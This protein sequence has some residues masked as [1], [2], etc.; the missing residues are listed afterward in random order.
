MSLE[1]TTILKNYQSAAIKKIIKLEEEFDG[2]LNFLEAGLGKSIIMLATLINNPVKTL[3]VCPAG[4]VNNWINEIKK[5]TNISDEKIL[6]YYGSNRKNIIITEEQIIYITSYS[7]VSREFNGSKFI[8]NSLFNNKVE[9]GRIILDEAHYIRN[10]YS[11]ISKSINFLGENYN[12][13]IK[14]WIVTATPIFN[15]TIDAY[16]Y[17]KFL[18]LEGI[19]SKADWTIAITKSIDGI[20]KLNMW[21]KKYGI[22][23]LKKDVLKE[24]SPKI[25]NKVILKFSSIEQEFYNSLKEYSQTRM[26]NLVD[27]IKYLNK[28]TI[29]DSGM[30]KIFHSNVMVYILRLKQACDSPLI[31]LKCMDRLK[32]CDLTTGVQKLK[33][34]NDSINKLDECPICYDTTANF[35]AEPC[36]HKCCEKCWN[37][38]FNQNITSCPICREY[39]SDIKKIEAKNVINE[40]QKCTLSELKSSAKIQKTIEL[41]K[42]IIK[43]GEKIV[44]VSQWVSMLSIM[45]NIFQNDNSLKDVKFVTLQGNVSLEQRTINIENFQNDKDI[46]VCFISLMSSSEGYNLTAANH[47]CFLD[48]WWCSAKMTQCMDR[49]HR[50]GQLKQVNV[51][52][53]EIENTIE[54]QIEKVVNKKNKIADLTT[55]KWQIN[56]EEYDSS[57]MKEII[58]LIDKQEVKNPST[59]F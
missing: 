25:E 11:G 5:H 24:L 46:K 16:A 22:T 30:K 53:L 44:I 1:I 7:V 43:N 38:M 4:L 55:K 6:K 42:S 8:K 52:H 34:Y 51:Y 54:Q 20:E 36:G 48:S 29:D 13:N 14:K 28:N 17:F 59:K 19:D 15:S 58:Q 47:V 9:F 50:I 27:R 56:K 21:M 45:K 10:T 26:K 12:I 35:I 49:T 40:K 39:V 37:K 32:N 23:L 33:F 41:T 18:Q 57:W 31:V 2:G 3:I